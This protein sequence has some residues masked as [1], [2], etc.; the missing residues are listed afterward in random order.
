MVLFAVM[1]VLLLLF[2]V[3]SGGGDAQFDVVSAGALKSPPA[4]AALKER[5][6]IDQARDIISQPPIIP[7]TVELKKLTEVEEAQVSPLRTAQ[8]LVMK[9]LL[10]K[11]IAKGEHL[12]L[13][14]N[15][16]HVSFATDA[17]DESKTKRKI[18]EDSPTNATG[19]SDA[20]DLAG[21]DD[22]ELKRP[23]GD[24]NS[25]IRTRTTPSFRLCHH[26]PADTIGSYLL[27]D[28]YW[29]DCLILPHLMLFA[30]AY[31]NVAFADG[32][33]SVVDVGANV[34]SCSMLMASRGAHVV[35]FEPVKRNYQKFHQS[36][37][38]SR[39]QDRVTL[40]TAAA[41]TAAGTAEITIERSNNGNSIIIDKS[42]DAGVKMHEHFRH[43]SDVEPISLVKADDFMT[44]RDD[45]PRDGEKKTSKG[46]E[47]RY[48][49]HLLKMDC[50]GSEFK[51]LLGATG[52]LER[53]SVDLIYSEVDTRI[54]RATNSEPAAMLRYLWKFQFSIYYTQTNRNTKDREVVKLSPADVDAFVEKCVDDPTDFTA[55]SKT[56]L[57]NAGEKAVERLLLVTNGELEKWLVAN[58]PSKPQPGVDYPQEGGRNDEVK[59]AE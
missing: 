31:S 10:V 35:S 46:D 4:L 12:S 6:V 49:V 56:V 52:L 34:G 8:R 36:I 2:L 19:N 53:G 29:K 51:A 39:Y 14:A 33:P 20:A 41:S 38:L 22:L 59:V 27:R 16:H 25:P 45:A 5:A 24:F 7:R 21:R 57:E 42:I 9:R 43:A 40:I 15:T 50:Q 26:G 13:I 28:G 23:C 11:D 37:R 32:M 58:P 17:A 1:F 3:S 30:Y 48:H 47:A 55:V 54:M 18:G 44:T